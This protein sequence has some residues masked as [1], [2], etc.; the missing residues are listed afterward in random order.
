MN[1]NKLNTYQRRLIVS[2]VVSLQY[3]PSAFQRVKYA[4][5]CRKYSRVFVCGFYG[6]LLMR[7]SGDGVDVRVWDWA[8][9]NC[10]GEEYYKEMLDYGISNPMTTVNGVVGVI[11]NCCMRYNAGK[12][13]ADR[14][15]ANAQ[16]AIL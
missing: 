10:A 3:L 8:A 11:E 2:E 12:T 1:V 15:A 7:Y 4:E 14:K 9:T 13:V 6:A 5:L 16:G